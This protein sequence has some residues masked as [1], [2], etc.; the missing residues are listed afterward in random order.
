MSRKQNAKPSTR[1]LSPLPSP[2]GRGAGWRIAL[3]ILVFATLLSF[4]TTRNNDFVSW[5]DFSVLV[6]NDQYRGLSF[7]HLKWM[8]T[9]P[10]AG[11]YQPLTWLSHAVDWRIYSGVNPAGYHFTNLV[12]HTLTAI[13]LLLVI[14]RLIGAV[15]HG[16]QHSDP[17]L[18]HSRHDGS[19]THAGTI[20]QSHRLTDDKAL[21]F[22]A[23]VGALLWAVHPLRVESVAWA[24][25]RRDVL[26]GLWLAVTVL[27]Y[28]RAVDTKPTGRRRLL[29]G[30][31]LACY[32][33]SLLSKAVG[34][35]LPVVLLIL[36]AYP[37]RRLGLLGRLSDRASSSGA[38][39][40]P[41]VGDGPANYSTINETSLAIQP[42]EEPKQV[43]LEK[44]PFL[45]PAIVFAG[46]AAWAQH[47]AGAMR[48]IEQHPVGLRVGQAFFGLMFYL[49]KTLWPAV[50]LPL[51]EQDPQAFALDSLNVI[52]ALLVI[53]LTAAVIAIRRKRPGLT[54]GWL[55]Y[56]VLLSPMLG[57]VQSGP[58]VVADRYSYIPTMVLSVLIAGVIC[59]I[60]ATGGRSRRKLRIG[61]V[62]VSAVL[63]GVLVAS[64]R[65]Q[66]HVWSDSYALWNHTLDRATD[67]PT[68]H[69][70]LAALLAA[71]GDYT[72]ARDHAFK[73]LERLPGNRSAHI[74]LAQASHALGDLETA[75]RC[76]EKALA[77]RSDDP[78]RMAALA[79]VYHEQ[80]R[81][82]EAERLLRQI[83]TIEP[84]LA[85]PRFDLACFLAGHRRYDEAVEEFNEALRLDPDY[86][87]AYYRVGIVL[88]R[89][90]DV[91]S[92]VARWEEGLLRSPHDTAIGAQLA[93]VLATSPVN[94]LRDGQRAVVLARRAAE[95]SA[96]TNLPATEALAAA[97]AR[98]GDFAQAITIA[99]ELLTLHDQDI[100]DSRKQRIDRALD[101]Y[102]TGQP[103]EEKVSE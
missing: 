101:F 37:L 78:P 63:V 12:L 74:S 51:Y 96:D 38:P 9:T 100:S 77:I 57:L 85:V 41:G 71:D 90:G 26:S 50:L 66:M 56:V 22:P 91:A 84:T 24:T 44:L 6:N 61:L 5:D 29:L 98:T 39:P 48:T 4:E 42:S 59:R 25:E 53:G 64:T 55:A 17:V 75:A 95:E 27:M 60:W 54:A 80:E 20:S 81:F 15:R 89:N 58:Q 16:P 19:P 70:N 32:V 1:E 67:T 7:E 87:E 88:K 69:V 28:L 33:L 62:A 86:V 11:H 46:L 18:R 35:T 76:F 40:L 73:A 10:F 93:W 30:L 79:A 23:L 68:A 99:E 43:L 94:E 102:R 92:A 8:F 103:F 45:L 13:V 21:V 49:Y 14:A 97:L 82:E 36:D 47:E 52:S 65:R 72:G 34:M 31:A 83:I 3:L 2:A